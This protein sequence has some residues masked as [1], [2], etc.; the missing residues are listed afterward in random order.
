M[1]IQPHDKTT[2]LLVIEPT[3][4][5][6]HLGLGEVWQY[7]ELMWFMIS[8]EIRGR[9][10]QMALGPLWIA[11]KPVIDMLLFTLIFGRL[12]KLPSEG[13]PYPLFTYAAIIP[14]SYFAMAT[15]NATGSLVS[16]MHVISK[17]YFPRLIVPLVAVLSGIVD[18]LVTFGVLLVL[19]A[20][21]GV[22]P[23]A[24]MFFLP[25][26]IGFAVVTATALGLWTATIAVRFRDLRFA[27]AYGL[28]VWMYATP[29]AYSATVVPEEWRFF[30]ELNPLFWVVEG[31]RWALLGLGTPPHE[32]MALPGAIVFVLLV[33]G[34][35]VF[36][37]TERTVV[38]LL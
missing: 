24:R 18:L 29:V 35:F 14:W 2:A 31:F 4:G 25:F 3:R 1:T 10:R 11:I 32:N 27:V 13:V 16:R 19:M 30:Y 20:F 9:Y 23:S 36:R 21:Y 7:R 17:V 37:R 12:A 28:Q 8:R 5:W 26:Y 34:A 15:N 22:A 33:S 38:D 6:S